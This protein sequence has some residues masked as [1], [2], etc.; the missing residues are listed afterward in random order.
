MVIASAFPLALPLAPALPGLGGAS[1]LA[2]VSP[3][4][5]L[6]SSFSS[7]LEGLGL[8]PA[9]AHLVW[10]PLPMLLVLVGAVV[11]VLVTV[12]L[13]RKISAAVQQRI[14][15]EYAGAL[16][17]LQPLADGL[18]LLF[19]ED[20]IPARADGLLFTLGPILVV[21]P[22]IL[23][24]LVVPFGQNLLI[25]NVGVGIFLWIAL[26]SIQPI[27]L[28]MSGYAS[29]NKYSLLGGLRAAAQSISY[30]IPLALAVLAVVM[31][32]NSLSTVDIV[33]QQTG[34][35]ILSWNIWRQPVGFVIFWICALA[36]CE[37]LPFD[38]PE[39]EEELVAGY[40]TEY[41]GMKFALFYLGSYINLVL[42]ALLVSVLY[43]GGWGF[44]VPVEWLAGALGQSVDAPVVQV[45]T[46]SLGIVMT[47][48][49]AYLLVFFAILLRW[50][51]P[52][53]RIDQLLNLGWKFLL[54]IALV[55]LLVTA[56][57][58][59]AFPA[60]FGG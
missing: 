9:V 41:A 55:N 48:L 8:T 50:T 7:L 43:L 15:P 49:K 59:L 36:E 60:V 58:K 46:G 33:N 24:W 13:E 44:P 47:V 18:K 3:G 37:R 39:A 5:D 30:E 52:R 20:I 42:S 2:V 1:S 12:W 10:L 32:S 25:S 35:G 4:L 22:V 54:P 19:K 53:V 29:N 51:V 40:Q 27:G 23:S 56:A 21:V 28:L 16:G 34:A 6:E 31:M 57:L 38:L 45:I 11:G 14:G 26:S 17:V